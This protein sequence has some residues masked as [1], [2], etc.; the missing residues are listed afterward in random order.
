[1]KSAP[2]VTTPLRNARKKDHGIWAEQVVGYEETA[3]G[4]RIPSSTGEGG[5]L[6]RSVNDSFEAEQ[7]NIPVGEDGVEVVTIQWSLFTDEERAAI[8]QRAE[9]IEDYYRVLGM[10]TRKRT[11]GDKPPSLADQLLEQEI[12]EKEATV[13]IKPDAGQPKVAAPP[14]MGRSVAAPA[15][16][17]QTDAPIGHLEDP[18]AYQEPAGTA[19]AGASP[20]SGWGRALEELAAA[21]KELQARKPLAAVEPVPA[22]APAPAPASRSKVRVRFVK[23]DNEEIAVWYDEAVIDT[24][25]SLLILGYDESDQAAVRYKPPSNPDTKVEMVVVI[26]DPATDRQV[27]LLIRSVGLNFSFRGYDLYV[28]PFRLVE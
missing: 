15:E 2:V 9:S 17:S 20:L 27:R 22:P 7:I 4:T 26:E 16:S 24:K 8:R 18:K 6:G 11:N 23:R 1:M 14:P 21:Q 12:R 13:S 5:Q 10:L 3:F 25:G 19:L 28:F